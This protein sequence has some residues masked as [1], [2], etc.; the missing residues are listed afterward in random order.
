MRVAALIDTYDVLGAGRQLAPMGPALRERGVAHRVVVFHRAGRRPAPY[1]SYLA[2]LGAD[3]VVV[4]ERRA[5]DVGILRRTAAE[6]E[7]F[8]PDVVETHGY[9][10]GTVAATLRAVGNPRWKWIAFFHGSTTEN[11]KVR[12]YHWLD[13][14]VMQRADRLAVMSPL[15]RDGFA[16]MGDRVRVVYNAVAQLPAAGDAPAVDLAG[17]FAPPPAPDVPMLGVV[18]RLSSEKGVDVFLDA[19]AHLA[20]DGVPFRAAVVGDG[21]DR[22]ALTARARALGLDD[23]VAFVGAVRNVAQAYQQLTCLVIP[24]RSEGLPNVLLEALDHDLP[25]V[26][27]RVGAVPQVL[28]DPLAGV[29]VPPEDPRALADGIRRGVALAGDPDAGAARAAAARRFS[30]D[31]RVDAHL[32]LY[33][34]LTA[35]ARA[36]RVSLGVAP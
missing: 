23:R 10:P 17:A 8:D 2:E 4:P 21:P 14:R 25:V 22:A 18:G 31:A 28:T 34:E 9:K 24:S 6:L 15:H 30:L 3:H 16:H 11:L 29:V 36:G 27:T 12:A 13:R 33:T 35:A 1:A 26:S 20:E 32:A 19:C 5:M 7:A